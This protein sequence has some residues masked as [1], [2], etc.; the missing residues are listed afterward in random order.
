MVDI[1]L[2]FLNPIN[3]DSQ[4]LFWDSFYETVSSTA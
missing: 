4:D 3:S 1:P 2:F